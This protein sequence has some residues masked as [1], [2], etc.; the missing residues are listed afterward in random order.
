MRLN[1]LWAYT[2]QC[3]LGFDGRDRPFTR[4]RRA[5]ERSDL[6]IAFLAA[7]NNHIIGRHVFAESREFVDSNL[8]AASHHRTTALDFRSHFV[9]GDGPSS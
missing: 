8:V 7:R 3:T 6:P 9:V 1:L 2:L 5:P 4:W